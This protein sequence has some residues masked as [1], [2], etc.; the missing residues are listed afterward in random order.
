M[1]AKKLQDVFEIRFARMPDEPTSLELDKLSTKDDS[2]SS[3]GESD[4]ESGNES[5]EE[6]EK[7]LKEL[8]DQVS[9]C[10]HLEITLKFYT[11]QCS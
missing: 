5:E 2:A 9:I 8:Q 3:L 1:M 6:R 10:L 4:S 7:K 11:S